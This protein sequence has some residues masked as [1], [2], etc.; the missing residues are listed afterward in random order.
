MRS[1]LTGRGGSKRCRGNGPVQLKA[2]TSPEQAGP[3]PIPPLSPLAIGP[4]AGAPARYWMGAVGGAIGGETRD[5]I[6]WELVRTPLPHWPG[7]TSI[8]AAPPPQPISRTLSAD[9]DRWR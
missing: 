1:S 9:G 3:R 2:S 4:T 5:P 7:R 6:G 8:R